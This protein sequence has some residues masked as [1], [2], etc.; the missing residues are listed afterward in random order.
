MRFAFFPS[1]TTKKGEA[2]QGTISALGIL[3]IAFRE[4]HASAGGSGNAASRFEVTGPKAARDGGVTH[5]AQLSGVCGVQ[6]R[7]GFSVSF[8][9]HGG[10]FRRAR[11][12][13]DDQRH[14]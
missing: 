2:G 4:R 8:L 10:D 11:L 7:G 1:T 9:V 5:S 6:G 14:N 13:A 12:G 3:H